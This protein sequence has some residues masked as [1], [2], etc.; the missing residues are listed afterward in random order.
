[1]IR[2]GRGNGALHIGMDHMESTRK[3][4]CAQYGHGQ[5]SGIG[6]DRLIDTMEK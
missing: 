6:C 1:M 5:L 3:R 4:V 2:A